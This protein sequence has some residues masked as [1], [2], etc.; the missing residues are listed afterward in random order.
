[1]D[2]DVVYLFFRTHKACVAVFPGKEACEDP[3]F[4]FTLVSDVATVYVLVVHPQHLNQTRFTAE[5]ML[6]RAVSEADPI[7]HALPMLMGFAPGRVVLNTVWPHIRDELQ[8]VSHL[9]ELCGAD[10]TISL[11][12]KRIVSVGQW[13]VT[14]ETVVSYEDA[15]AQ[16]VVLKSQRSSL[17]AMKNAMGLIGHKASGRGGRRNKRTPITDNAI[18]ASEKAGPGKQIHSSDSSGSADT[19][20]DSSCDEHWQD[21]YI[22]ILTSLRKTA[23]AKT[24]D[25]P[26]IEPVAGDTSGPLAAGSSEAVSADGVPGLRVRPGDRSL[27]HHGLATIAEVRS[28]GVLVGFGI[29]CRRHS[30]ASDRP[31]IVCKKQLLLGN[32]SMSHVEAKLRLKRWYVVGTQARAE[33]WCPEKARSS[34]LGFGGQRL[35]LLGSDAEEWR[36]ISDEELNDMARRA[37]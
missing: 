36:D 23:H 24:K 34:H 3:T 1:M 16:E 28:R 4:M 26:I 31:G 37:G 33:T 14:A 6:L 32:P 22:Y 12:T 27:E 8:F 5:V 19:D 10:W 30:D 18:R 17:A 2:P 11:M 35:Q 13:L 20:E 21:M 25:T 29:T 15:K 9:I 7:S